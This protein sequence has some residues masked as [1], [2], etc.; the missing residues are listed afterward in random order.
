MTT[1]ANSGGTFATDGGGGS[2]ARLVEDPMTEWRGLFYLQCEIQ[3]MRRNEES[4]TSEVGTW[5]WCDRCFSFNFNFVVIFAGLLKL[6]SAMELL[7]KFM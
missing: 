6:I 1:S 2:D 5:E 3:E 7:L 4:S